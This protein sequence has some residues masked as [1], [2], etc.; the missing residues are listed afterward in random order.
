MLLADRAFLYLYQGAGKTM[1]EDHALEK[2]KRFQFQPWYIKLWRRR[3]LLVIPFEA[4]SLWLANFGDKEADIS[5]K[6][7][8]SIA[9]GMAH[10]PGRMNWV[11]D[12]DEVKKRLEDALDD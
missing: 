1:A 10:M 7:A 11:Y 12:W 3:W 5:W 8:W 4:L 6:V 9:H 2:K